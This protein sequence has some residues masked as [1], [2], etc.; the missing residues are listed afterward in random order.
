MSLLK[1]ETKECREGCSGSGSHTVKYFTVAIE[2]VA[3][4]LFPIQNFSQGMF[5][6]MQILEHVVA[7]PLFYALVRVGLAKKQTEIDDE[8][9]LLAQMLWNE[10]DTRGIKVWEFRFFGL[11]RNIFVAEFPNG[12]K[13]TYEGTPVPSRSAHQVWWLDDKA[14]LKKT[15][16]QTWAASC[17]GWLRDDQKRCS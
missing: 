6:K 4:Y 15:V 17:K 13:I 11:A 1:F 14:I 5:Y 12:D 9:Q 2:T 8:T 7:V 3:K 10:A 16:S